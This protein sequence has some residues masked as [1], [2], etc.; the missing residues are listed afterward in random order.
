MKNLTTFILVLMSISLSAQ[1]LQETRRF[2]TPQKVVVDGKMKLNLHKSNEVEVVINTKGVK[3]QD[4]Y[5]KD[6]GDELLIRV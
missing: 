5:T 6:K 4:I 3:L 1:K 2:S